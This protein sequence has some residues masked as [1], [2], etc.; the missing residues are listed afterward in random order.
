MFYNWNI[1]RL[2]FA[3]F[4]GN[5]FFDWFCF[6]MM[7]NQQISYNYNSPSIN[8]FFKL[9]HLQNWNNTFVTAFKFELIE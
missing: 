7:A 5:Y 8:K 9:S 4:L 1:V 3:P 6:I 2:F